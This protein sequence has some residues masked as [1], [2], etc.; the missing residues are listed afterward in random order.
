MSCFSNLTQNS[1]PLRAVPSP[2]FAPF[3]QTKKELLNTGGQFPAT[4]TIQL[5]FPI[6]IQS[7][8]ESLKIPQISCGICP[9]AFLT[10]QQCITPR[11]QSVKEFQLVCQLPKKRFSFL[12]FALV[13]TSVSGPAIDQSCRMSN[14]LQGEITYI[15]F[16]PH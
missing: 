6:T 10:I 5:N 11:R 1:C 15:S 7:P 14:D 12:K 13:L 3:G 4:T 9:T 2:P 16:Y 8:T